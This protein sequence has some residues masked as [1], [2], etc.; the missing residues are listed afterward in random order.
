M[1]RR[2]FHSSI[3]E[4]ETLFENSKDDRS[5]LEALEE[6]LAHRKTERAAKLRRRVR[7]CLTELGICTSELKQHTPSFERVPNMKTDRIVEVWNDVSIVPQ[8][9]TAEP[10]LTSATLQTRVKD[11]SQRVIPPLTSAPESFCQHGQHSRY[12][13]RLHFVVPK[14][15]LQEIERG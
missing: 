7:M 3:H 15:L 13:H 8:K 12:C 10:N 6:E 4:L 1:N 14:I 11:H 2:Y 9:S 5:V